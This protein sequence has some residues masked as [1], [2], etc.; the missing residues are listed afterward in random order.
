M[1]V[2]VVSSIDLDWKIEVLE[3]FA[4]ENDAN[5]YVADKRT[6]TKDPDQYRIDAREL[7][8]T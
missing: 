5:G 1:T 6:Q 2:Y 4:D 8:T 3:V 7:K